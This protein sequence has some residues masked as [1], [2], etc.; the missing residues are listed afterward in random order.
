MYVTAAKMEVDIMLASE[1]YGTSSDENGQFSDLGRKAAVYAMRD[2]LALDA[3]GPTSDN[4]FRWVETMGTRIYSCYRSPNC[5]IDEFADYIDR[6]FSSV[7]T[8]AVPVIV[9]GDFNAYSPEWGSPDENQRGSLLADDIHSIN[10]YVCNRG[11]QPTFVRGAS[12]THIDVTFASEAIIGDV[13][14]WKV[15]DEESNVD[16]RDETRWSVFKLDT[17]KLQEAVRRE[18]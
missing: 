18:L 17:G 7:R 6:L 16:A 15:V 12:K 8:S 4:G 10:L 3:I 9:A 11:N 13:H 1:Q 5:T 14:G 2:S